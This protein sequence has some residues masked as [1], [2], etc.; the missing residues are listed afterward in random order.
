[1][2]RIL[3][4]QDAEASQGTFSSAPLRPGKFWLIGTF[5]FIYSSTK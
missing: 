4:R 2:A 1:M 5:P 3:A